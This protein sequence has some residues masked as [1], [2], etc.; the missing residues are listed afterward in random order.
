[1]IFKDC[2]LYCNEEI[3]KWLNVLKP[4]TILKRQYS[5]K[6]DNIEH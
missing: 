3:A 1:M 4:Q 2:K 6:S 5:I